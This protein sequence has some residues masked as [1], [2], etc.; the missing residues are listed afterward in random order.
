MKS[1]KAISLVVLVITV[2]VLSIL[3]TTVII[4]ISDTNIIS[5][6]SN[7]VEQNQIAQEKETI[8]VAIT[9]AI[10]RN[11]RNELV[12][13]ELQNIVN[14]KLSEEKEIY[15]AEGKY[16]IYVEESNRTYSV[17]ID[18]YS[19]ELEDNDEYEIAKYIVEI[20]KA[21]NESVDSSSTN[22]EIFQKVQQKLNYENAEYDTS[23]VAMVVSTKWDFTLIEDG[24]VKKGRYAY[25]SIADGAIDIY[26]TY[27]TQGKKTVE[28]TAGDYTITGNSSEYGVRM[29]EDGTFNITFKDLTIDVSSIGSRRAA[30]NGNYGT[31]TDNLFLNIFLDGTNYLKG[32]DAP[33]LAFAYG[34][35]NVGGVT[36]GSTLTIQGE[37]S[38]EVHGCWAN[39]AIGS[40]YTGWES[41]PG[42]ANN[43]IINSGT[44]LAYGYRV[45]ATIGGALRK[46]VNNIV[47]NGGDVNVIQT[48]NGSGIGDYGGTA[49]NV[50]V[51]GGNIV[52]KGGEYGAGINADDITINGGVI[53]LYSNA[54]YPALGRGAVTFAGITSNITVNGGT[55]VTYQPKTSSIHVGLGELVINGG[56][57]LSKSITA[58]QTS[59]AEDGSETVTNITTNPTDGTNTLYATPVKLENVGGGVK[60]E[61]ITFSDNI[62][63]GVTDMYTS[64]LDTE[65]KVEEEGVIY[66]YLPEGTRT[67]TIVAGKKTY[68]G[69]ITTATTNSVVVLSEK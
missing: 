62:Q 61:K 63:Y 67:V 31:K 35:P 23:S 14:E 57:I 4:T 36:T 16:Y 2:I 9:Q 5:Q 68:T 39:P 25:L 6:A 40:G 11:K 52:A 43:I 38:L 60:I 15:E 28:Y 27:Y 26:S 45:A 33:A 69:T 47:I 7:S 49:K 55:V 10:L 17:D 19:V 13:E 22:A 12:R 56:S 29:R 30:F 48:D 3:A 34:T 65:F 53:K 1:K 50:V 66:L 21:Y 37:G 64:E 32:C 54:A 51:N 42:D 41:C 58:I 46:N 44:I 8:S 20:K 24:S 18:S 59:T